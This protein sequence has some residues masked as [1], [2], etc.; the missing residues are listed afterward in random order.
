MESFYKSYI[1]TNIETENPIYNIFN[2]ADPESIF[3]YSLIIISITWISTKLIYDFNILIG[4]VFCSIIIL[5]L[6]D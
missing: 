5:N 1:N 2:S 4:L 3:M 6:T